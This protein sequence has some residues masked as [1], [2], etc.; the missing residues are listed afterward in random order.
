MAFRS[1]CAE[2][3]EEP[4]SLI[5]EEALFTGSSEEKK[6][7]LIRPFGIDPMVGGKS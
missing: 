7:D 1:L 3:G 5:E 6:A 4:M 2:M